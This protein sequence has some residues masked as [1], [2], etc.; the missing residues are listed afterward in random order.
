[1]NDA[2]G[3]PDWPMQYSLKN[4]AQSGT[5]MLVPP[6]AQRK[7]AATI[8]RAKFAGEQ[9][10]VFITG[11]IDETGKLQSLRSIRTQDARTQSAIQALQQWE[12]LPAQQDGRPVASKV[13]IGVTVTEQ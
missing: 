10:P 6:F 4:H 5:G 11:T 7:V 9:G 1:M 8:A 2:G 3:G 12:F 13:L